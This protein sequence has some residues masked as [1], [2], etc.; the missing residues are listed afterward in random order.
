MNKLSISRIIFAI[1][2][3]ILLNAS[4]VFAD[5]IDI[6]CPYCDNFG[7]EVLNDKGGVCKCLNCDRNML[8]LNGTIYTDD[9]RELPLFAYVVYTKKSED[10]L[11][12]S[13]DENVSVITEMNNESAE[14]VENSI[15][16][17]END[18]KTI[19]NVNYDLEPEVDESTKKEENEITESYTEQSREIVKEMVFSAT[20]I[21]ETLKVENEVIEEVTTSI[22]I[23]GGE[24]DEAKFNDSSTLSEINVST[25]SMV[26]G[27]DLESIDE[28]EQNKLDNMENNSIIYVLMMLIAVAILGRAMINYKGYKK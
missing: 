7:V 25:R 19:D 22:Q 3:T 9:K 16:E 14:G 27:E 15:V 12:E 24:T 20:T 18:I 28:F 8:I 10:K 13:D 11:D 5:T 23:L 1:L 2:I 17:Y 4:L 26:S 21:F 6:H